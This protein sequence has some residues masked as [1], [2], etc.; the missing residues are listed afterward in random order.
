MLA[1]KALQL[2]LVGSVL[3]CLAGCAIAY[4][5]GILIRKTRLPRAVFAPFVALCFSWIFMTGLGTGIVPSILL[6][7]GGLLGNWN[8]TDNEK[9]TAILAFASLLSVFTTF[10]ISSKKDEGL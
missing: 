9:L 8:W 6:L 4:G 10:W 2:T 5:L 7:L 1:T 3:L